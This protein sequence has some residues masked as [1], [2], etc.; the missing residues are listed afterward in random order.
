MAC[1]FDNFQHNK[2]KFQMD[3]EKCND[4][5]FV[6]RYIVILN[7][8]KEILKKHHENCHQTLIDS[9]QTD[10]LVVEKIQK[11][12]FECKFQKILD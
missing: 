4:Q 3:V 11:P 1:Y 6:F 9:S 5:K 8:V 12:H 7:K 10:A 2:P